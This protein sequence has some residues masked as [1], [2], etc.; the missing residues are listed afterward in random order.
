MKTNLFSTGIPARMTV[1]SLTLFLALMIIQSCGPS[2]A[3]KNVIAVDPGFSTYVSGYTGGIIS[4]ASSIN[5]QLAQATTAF[6]G[7]GKEI[8][9]KLFELSPSVEGKTSWIDQYTIAFQPDQELKPA[10]TYEVRFNL[11]KIMDVP[12][13]YKVLN[14]SFATVKQ[15]FSVDVDGIFAADPENLTRESVRGTLMTADVAGAADVEKILTAE[16]SGKNLGITWEHSED[17]KLHH[18]IVNGVVRS[19]EES[20]VILQWNGDPLGISEK[21]SREVVIPSLS[22][23][24]VMNTRVE[25]YP[26]QYVALQFSDPILDKQNLDGLITMDE[27]GTLRFIIDGNEVRVYPPVNQTGSKTIHINQGIKNILGYKLK[28][29]QVVTVA[30]EQM[31]PGV[32]LVSKGVILPNTQG[33]IFPFEAVN[34]KAVDVSIVKIYENNI[35]QFLQVNDLN[36]NYELQRVGYPVVHK[37]VPLNNSGVTDLSK[38]NRFT[39]DLSDMLKTDPGAIYQVEIGF[40]PSYSLYNCPN[41]TAAEDNLTQTQNGNNWDTYN[42]SSNWDYYEDSYPSGYDW[43][44]RDNP[45]NVSYYTPNRFVKSNLLSSDLGIMAKTGLDGQMLVAVTDL[46]STDPVSGADIELYDFQKQLIQ[47]V[48]TDNEGLA[49]FKLVRKPFL[50]IASHDKQKGYLKMDDGEALSMSNFNV[51]GEKIQEGI[52]GFLYGE[53]GVWRPGDSLHLTFI[54]EDKNK[55]L[56]E[57]HPVI[58]ELYNPLGQLDRKL[59]KTVSLNGFYNFGTR[60]DDDAPTGNWLAK[61]IVGGAEFTKQ[62]K[63]ETIKPNRLKIDL[64]FGSDRL[65]AGKT[66]IGK[67][68][69]KWLHGAIAG[70]LKTHF[71]VTLRKSETTFDNYQDYVFDD[72]TRSFSSETYTLYDGKLDN[73]GNAS[74][75]VD[76]QME[77]AAPGVLTASFN[78]KVFEESGDF[79]VDMFNMP[80]YP[81]ESYVGLKTPKGDKARGMLLT[82]TTHQILIATV[83]AEGNPVSRTGVTMDVYKLNWRWWWDNSEDDLSDYLTSN[84][85][86]V[87]S[88]QVINTVN[89]RG[90]A[91][92]R[93]NYPDWGRF[94]IRVTDPVSGHSAGKVVYVDWPGWA[95][96]GQRENPGGATMLSFATDKDQYK[97]GDNITLTIPGSGQG[98]AFISVENGSSV[99][100]NFWMETRQGDNVFIIKT[101]ERFSPNVYVYVSL[102]QPY[103]QTVNDLP[104][105]LY[106]VMPV[107]IDNPETHLKPVI[108]MGDELKPESEVQVK[109]SEANGKPMTYTVAVVDEGLLDLTNYRTP[110]PWNQFYKREGLG[111]QTWD[112]FDDV[113][114]AF[115][116][117]LERLLSVGGDEGIKN[118]EGT[119]ANRFKPVVVF[120]GPYHLDAGKT[121][122]LKF[123][124]PSYIGAV[125]TMVVAGDIGAYGSVEKESTVKQPVMVLATLPRVLGPGEDAVLPV[126][127]FSYDAKAQ[128]V[129]VEVKPNSYF[130]LSGNPR[131][132]VDFTQPGDKVINFKLKVKDRLG[133]GVVDVNASAGSNQAS[134]HVELQIRNPNPP[135]VKV[136][137]ALVDQGKSWSVDF[138]NV[139]MPGTN[140]ATLEVST[141]PPIN[142][143]KRLHYLIHYPYG[144]IEQTTS[145]VFPQLF[146]SDVVDLSQD[147]KNNIDANIKAGIERIK[148]FQNTDGGF[149]Y[150]PDAYISDDWC[151][152]YVGHFLLEARKKGYDVPESMMRSWIRFQKR[153]ADTWARGPMKNSELVQAYRLYTLA[154]AGEP[155]NGNMN[156]LREMNLPV[157]AKWRLAAAYQLAGISDVA[158]DLTKNISMTPEDYKEMSYT[159]GSSFRD[160]AMILETLIL[161][162]KRQEGAE[163]MKKISAALSDNDRWLSTQ[164]T[165]FA[166]MAVSKFASREEKSARIEFNYTWNKGKSI[167]AVTDL[168]LIQKQLPLKDENSGNLSFENSGKGILYV[169][170]IQQGIPSQAQETESSNNLSLIVTYKDASGNILDLS[171]IQQGTELT[172][173]V[174][175]VNPG[176][177]GDYKELALSQIFPS[178][179]EIVNDRLIDNAPGAPADKTN[180]K[181]IRDDRVYSFFD[182][183]PNSRRFF[184]VKLVAT[185]AGRYYMPGVYCE[186]MYDQSINARTKGQW[187]NI[188]PATVE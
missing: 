8:S 159:Y 141:I 26:Q 54:L 87:I 17:Q 3:K 69:V 108:T 50:L 59:I 88:H 32:R 99:L 94:L 89:G 34:L 53:R 57:A 95:G 155:M 6:T 164:E 12:D 138:N 82:D 14:Y 36:G 90:E 122:S 21:D 27:T 165:A 97:V 149:R 175:V 41:M 64:D 186:A 153:M 106:G 102:L 115:G 121:A 184:T 156:R 92:F 118:P 123:K 56:P 144:C 11:G 169:R 135:A 100:E 18:F 24:K 178:G 172:A 188:T 46:I 23:F 112:L 113:I 85:H 116:G 96:R 154:L 103:N 28:T 179:F 60:T 20:K 183:P 173:E 43:Q 157:A 137:E 109:I 161:M 185:Y 30:F 139:G 158:N 79:S 42:E 136:Y 163:L 81:Y 170:I 143:D 10:T 58:F 187:I 93:I 22:D 150:W 47:S 38:W 114:G 180:Y 7:S 49:K 78:G 129:E 176:M 71:E 65:I 84:Y 117:S 98:R 142:L 130:E 105:R 1:F 74:I 181:D 83:D 15:N 63:I 91:R 61:V 152:S 145:S 39:L 33:L 134:D 75:P 107:K 171:N 151:S 120:M 72:P 177:R 124:M 9:D 147:A 37:M 86:Q 52:K 77:S 68:S 70:N 55:L 67:L 166:L 125:R 132:T 66:T 16:Q 45:C 4:A 126:T 146:L 168:P 25:H 44:E 104:I 29:D 13:K 110:D 131:A 76:L 160:E 51:G 40:K 101:D 133:V 48:T 148:T 5:I 35:T 127:V 62:V 174:S 119:K 182:L 140:Q 162:N 73:N 80:F 2:E 31:K 19:N 167:N 111:V 128:H